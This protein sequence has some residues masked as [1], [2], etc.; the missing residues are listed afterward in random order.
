[1][2]KTIVSITPNVDGNNGTITIGEV[3][4][5]QVVVTIP[6][7]VA[8]NAIITDQ[9]DNGLT[10]LSFDSINA[11]AG[12]STTTAGSFTGVLSAA[13]GSGTRN[14]SF[15]FGTLTNNDTN[16][17]TDEI[18]TIR[19]SVLVRDVSPNTNNASRRNQATFSSDNS[20]VSARAP[21]L[22]I[23]LPVLTLNKTVSPSNADAGDT[24]TYTVVMR[25]TGTSPAF[26]VVISDPLSNTFLNLVPGSVTTSSGIVTTGN[27]GSDTTVRVD[28]ASVP[29]PG[30]VTVTFNVL[31]D[32]AAVS[33]DVLNNIASTIGSS[34][35][36]IDPN[37]RGFGPVTDDANVNIAGATVVKTVLPL[38]SSEQSEPSAPSGLGNPS[39]VDLTI[40]EEVTFNIVATL[41]EGVS[42]S[43]IIT[44]TLPNNATGQ[45]HVVSS[46]VI[47]VGANLAPTLSPAVGTIGLP[48]V[49]VFDFGSVTNTPD[50]VVNADDQIVVQVTAVVTSANV[51]SGIEVLRNN[52]LIQ[53]NTGLNESGYADVEVVEPIL[54]VDKT[55][56][57]N[58]ADAGDTITFSI[59]I[60]N[61][62][63]PSSARAFEAT[64]SD[65][66]PA[67]L[68]FA[69]N[70]VSN[71]GG[72]T[73]T[74]L[75]ESGGVVTATWAEFPIGESVTIS[76]DVTV[77]TS[78][79]PEQVITNT[80]TVGWTSMPGANANERTYTD[81]ETHQVTITASGLDKIVFATSEPS[82]G[83]SQN[84]PEPDLTIGEH[85]T[86]RMTVSLP[87]GTSS[88]AVFTDQLPRTT[89]KFD[90][91]SSQIVSIGANLTIANGSA[92]DAGLY[93][94][95]NADGY[96][97]LITW[98]LGNISNLFDNISDEKDQIVF[99]V[100]AVVVDNPV[101]QTNLN[102][103]ANVAT[104]SV[105]G[106]TVTDSALVDI[107]EP[108]VEVS[109]TT[110]PASITADAGDVLTYQL[111]IAHR[112]NSSA[113]AFNMIIE[114]NLPVPG[115]QWIND[116]TVASTCP[117]WS[118]D[119]TAEPMIEFSFNTLDLT[120]GS[121]VITYD[122][123]VD[124]TVNPTVTYANTANLSYT[125]TPVVV[126]G[127]SRTSTGSDKT[128]FITAT[129]AVV[130]VS[131]SSSLGDTG[132]NQG[133]P[134][135]PDLA[136]GE[137]ID[138][139]LT[140][141]IPEGITTNA[142]VTDQLPL[143]LMEVVS[144]TVNSTGINIST[145][146]PGTPVITDSNADSYD[147]RVVFD[148]GNITNIPDGVND[149][150]D[151]IT[152]TVTARLL[153][154]S[155]NMA[156]NMLTNNVE[157]TYDT[158]TPLTDDADVEVVEPNLG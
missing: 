146:L 14:A 99:E 149:A 67:G 129:P 20:S 11:S 16:N 8:T 87:E 110:L 80:A 121:C 41:A 1:M 66:I 10:F 48:N 49:V 135:V 72:W 37:E 124:N 51:N 34:L 123:Q 62:L 131:G 7:G 58:S 18:I 4:Q 57:V 33:G 77:D 64:L 150:G 71:V 142:V 15:D 145:T 39:L 61:T 156:I 84:G 53:Y 114:D 69:G 44:D 107:V 126:A 154:V 75:Q 31:I 45:M 113:D 36:G 152:M 78:V 65:S 85:V 148:F 13:T 50:G 136:I 141:I 143:G 109:K 92:G 97:D 54:N 42:P 9:L 6:E 153:D 105:D 38:T 158:G 32:D 81:A 128:D 76:Y 23:R 157:F 137:E 96:M 122:V 133:N 111:T 139:T 104:F 106:S 56:S 144:A 103:V 83:N 94:D 24:V 22:R 79:S 3:I 155:A 116:G 151:Q 2:D 12:L 125:S 115:T 132:N 63:P 140:I 17:A 73:P 43:V 112:A 134:L 40:G 90:V 147:D 86:Y 55:G 21:I 47:S 30:I 59:T 35:P 127:Q 27:G 91:I 102:D 138:F 95:T 120:T 101:N 70:L 100:V 98:N 29:N 82:T 26:D 118:V 5:Y 52:V 130:K 89:A 46:Q 108:I 28:V 93:A 117:G 19:Y 74:T 88:N 119:S 60:D 68:T 25:N